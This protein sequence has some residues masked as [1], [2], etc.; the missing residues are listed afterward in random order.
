MARGTSARWRQDETQL[1]QAYQ[2]FLKHYEAEMK[3]NRP[4]YAEHKFSV[5]E[6]RKAAERGP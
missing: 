6:F 2:D 3:A 1:R 5:E 4:E